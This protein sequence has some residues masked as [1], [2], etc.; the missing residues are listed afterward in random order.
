MS[1]LMTMRCTADP[2]QLEAIAQQDPEMVRTILQRALD[3]GLIAHRFFGNANEVFVVDE[4]P[5]EAS[6]QEFFDASP[7]IPVMFGKAGLQGEPEVTFWR[8]LEIDDRV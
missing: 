4:W 2:R 1:V 8:A 3:H 7:E 6:F 5:D